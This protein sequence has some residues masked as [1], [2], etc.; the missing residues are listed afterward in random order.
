MNCT[1]TATFPLV[2]NSVAKGLIYPQRGLR[3]RCPLSPYLFIIY[4]VVFS[5]LLMQAKKYKLIHGLSFS[6][7]FSISY[8]LF[9]DDSLIFSR[10]SGE[11]CKNLKKAFNAYVAASG[12]IFNYGKS[13]MFFICNTN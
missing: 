2:I 10:A 12:E 3:Q 4:A 5:N 6:I 1:S 9:V 8:A 7:I 13:S 11:D